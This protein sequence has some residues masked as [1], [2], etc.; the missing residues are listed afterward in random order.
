VEK[1][2]LTFR[3][4]I[5]SGVFGLGALSFVFAAAA[6]NVSN[7]IFHIVASRLLGPSHYG[8]VGAILSII[9]VLTVPLGAAQLAV[10]QSILR[11]TSNGPQFSIR[12]VAKQS[13]V[14]GLVAMLAFAI[15]TPWLDGFLHIK[16]S[17]PLLLVALWM[18][19]AS[20]GA[21]LQGSL[22]GEYRFRPV[23]FA[24][25]AGGGPIRL[26]FGTIL[27]AEGAG[28]AGAVIAT[29]AG[30]FFTTGWLLY[31][32]RREL[33]DQQDS[34]SIRATTR[35]M[36]LS[37][38]ALASYTALIG[39]DT[40][41]ARHFFHAR[42]AGLYAAGAVAAHIALFVPGALVTVTFPHLADG[43]GIS[44]H[45][46]KMFYQALKLTAIL[47]TLSAIVLTLLSSF[48]AHILFGASYDG[49]ISIIGVLSFASVFLGALS[50]FVYL[51]IARRSSFALTPFFGVAL[52]VVLI[53]IHHQSINSVAIVMLIVAG[54]TLVAAAAPALR[55][56]AIASVWETSNRLTWFDLPPSEIDLT[57]VVPFYNPGNRFGEHMKEVVKVL[58]ASGVSYEIFAV[59]DGTTD[60][61]EEQIS[62][63][64]SDHFAL[65]HLEKNQGKG[66]ALRVGLARGRGSY[67]GFI[68][69]DGDLPARVIVNFLRI[70]AQ[71]QPDIIYGSKRHP[72]SNV[73]YPRIRR[74]YSWGYQ[75]LNRALFRYPPRDTQTGVKFFRREVLAD[76]LPRTLEKRF[77]FDLELFV[78]ARHRGF[79]DFVEMP[80]DIVERFS[81]SI[82]L[83]A[84]RQMLTDTF[85][86][87]YRLRIVK[88][89]EPKVPGAALSVSKLLDDREMMLGT[90]V[91]SSP[92][93]RRPLRILILN[94]R[95]LRHAKAGGA[96]LYTHRVA[97]EWIGA[98]HKVTLFCA[99]V[100][101]QPDDEIMGGLRIIRRGS[102]VTVYR[103]A[104]AYYETEGR[105]QFDVVID[106]INTR[107]FFAIKWVKDAAVVA[108]SHQ[109]CREL[110]FYQMPLPMA[111]TGR[112]WLEPRWLRAYRDVAT[113]AL[114]QSGKES[115]ENYGLRRVV[116][117]PEG[118]DKMSYSPQLDREK[119]PTVV[120]LGRL[121]AHKRPEQAL[122]AFEALRTT[123][124]SAVM[125]I[126][127]TGPLERKLRDVAPEGVEFLGHVTDEEK[128][129]RLARAH[130]LLVT[131]VR[132]GWGL[133]VTEAAQVGTPTIGYDVPGLRDSILA[134]N[135]VLVTPDPKHLSAALRRHLPEWFANG[136]P[137]I[138]PGG[139]IPWSEVAERI[140]LETVQ[141]FG[142]FREPNGEEINHGEENS[143]I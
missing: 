36:T 33:F 55:S 91:S 110:W 113:V 35:D 128:M 47:G 108:I 7:F 66:A 134:S 69:G 81:S 86:I 8:A 67:L 32:T 125:W 4:W 34:T 90:S 127:G 19:M 85:A 70:V 38:S 97:E 50:L 131:S 45:S 126:I 60:H 65:I 11:R 63:H 16:S 42:E 118:T 62:H 10:T 135:G 58:D 9:S 98:G 105:G 61:S 132:E 72:D 43:R 103:E 25:F 74:L 95:D 130:V 94:W 30:Q 102:A 112:F 44:A 18:P 48:V 111:L 28:V 140:L 133:V 13:L 41:L 96:E 117:V 100:E 93:E 68:D 89:Y 24:S 139:V 59:S 77:A 46:R 56:M 92:N 1:R 138:T 52:A 104:R 27:L 143:S 29:I 76:V 71:Q 121:E 5:T 83:R 31:S 54:V 73:V 22:I 107:P 87:F 141:V 39:V 75:Q 136:T 129:S 123:L 114:T 64:L 23:A 88:F 15:L 99:Y 101:G 20:L 82:S 79:D 142:P 122:R 116:V 119:Q 26:I 2:F 49:A 40:F 12:R 51:H 21:V 80:V 115:L 109:V 6:I 37:I 3:H 14:A 17:L 84:V 57:L 137:R 53:S 106:E 120:F 78:V 124:P